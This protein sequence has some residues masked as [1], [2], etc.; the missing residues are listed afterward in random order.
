MG[1]CMASLARNPMLI[2]PLSELI[3]LPIL[4]NSKQISL[5]WFYLF[6]SC[7]ILIKQLTGRSNRQ[8][9]WWKEGESST[10]L[11]GE[12]VR[13]RNRGKE[14]E[15]PLQRKVVVEDQETVGPKIKLFHPSLVTSF[16]GISFILQKLF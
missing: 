4:E 9:S 12:D 6:V 11:G 16:H 5:E 14:G 7:L 8:Q 15:L 3:K 13:V 2:Q 1:R 10:G